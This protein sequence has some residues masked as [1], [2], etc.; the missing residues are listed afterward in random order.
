MADAWTEQIRE[1]EKD[2]QI[3]LDQVPFTFAESE[4]EDEHELGLEVEG[5]SAEMDT[6]V[7]IPTPRDHSFFITNRQVTLMVEQGS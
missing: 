3:A 5:T 4:E 1:K 7:D 6:L 2:I